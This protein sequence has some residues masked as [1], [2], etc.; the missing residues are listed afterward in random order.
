MK[1]VR[2]VTR[3]EAA[4][5]RERGALPWNKKIWIAICHYGAYFANTVQ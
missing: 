3:N 2:S 5:E 4:A 1:G